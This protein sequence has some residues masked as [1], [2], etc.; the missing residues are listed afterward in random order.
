MCLE[1]RVVCGE[2]QIWKRGGGGERERRVEVGL[3]LK[4][5]CKQEE[6]EEL[7]KKRSSG[8][9]SIFILNFLKRYVAARDVVRLGDA[10]PLPPTN[11]AG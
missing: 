7:S 8:V 2:G 5:F 10:V 1:N 4:G 11:G 6:E 9:H 3:E